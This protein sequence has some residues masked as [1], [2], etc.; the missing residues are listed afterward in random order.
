MRRLAIKSVHTLWNVCFIFFDYKVYKCRIC[1]GLIEIPHTGTKGLGRKWG[2]NGVLTNG[3]KKQ[4]LA[5]FVDQR[6]ALVKVTA[7]YKPWWLNF[8]VHWVFLVELSI[9]AC[10]A[11]FS[12]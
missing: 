10:A 8:V 7:R 9:C 1:G 6:F 12:A 2:V 5:P 4:S 3:Q 11:S